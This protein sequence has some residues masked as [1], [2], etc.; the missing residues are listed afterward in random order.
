[1]KT[2]HFL[3]GLPRSGSTLLCNILA[4]NPMIHT[5]PTSACHET[6][7]SLRNNWHQ[8]VEHRAAPSLRNEKNLQRMM[9]AMLNSY[10]DTDRP[11][12]IDKGRGW[13]SMVEMVEFALSRPVKIIVP[14]RNIT[15]ILASF[16]KLHR[17]QRHAYAEPGDYIIAQT[18]QGRA[19][20]L[21][22]SGEVVGLAYNRLRDVLQRGQRDRLH[23]VE[24]ENLTHDPLRTLDEIYTFLDLP[25][26]NH[27]FD[28]IQ[29][30]TF[31]DDSIHGL[32]LHTV[33]SAV[34]PV[35]DD[36]ETVLGVDLCKKYA[37]T[38]FWRNK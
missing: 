23:F 30:Y 33:R 3:S 31:E 14:V 19:E 22:K 34:K 26:F 17:S 2:I 16:E 15:H 10:H 4:Q 28:D 38:E 13:I 36:S 9:A 8:W 20:N 35:K 32:P 12:I 24:F 5:T 6:L 27:N 37:G 25:G 18:T 21:L 11:I 29:Q 7:F 1:M